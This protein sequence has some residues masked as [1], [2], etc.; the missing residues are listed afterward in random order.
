MT[1]LLPKNI[2]RD[3]SVWYYSFGFNETHMAVPLDYG[4]ILNHHESA[5]A[6]VLFGPNENMYFQV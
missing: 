5:N 6:H 1:L 4:S 2:P 3:L